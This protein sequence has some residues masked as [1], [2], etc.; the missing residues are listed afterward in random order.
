MKFRV[1]EVAAR[2]G[3]ARVLA[4]GLVEKW[5]SA[6]AALE[7]TAG[8]RKA[9]RRSVAAES[10]REAAEQ[11]IGACVGLG[12]DAV[13]HRVVH[14]GARFEEPTRVTAEVV[15]EIEK[16]SHLAPLHNKLA[17]DGIE[18][19]LKLLPGTPAVAVFDTAFH[20]TIP[21]VAARYA[22]PLEWA[23]NNELRRYGFHGISHKYVT[24]KLLACLRRE[25]KG[26][27]LI[28][29]HLGNGA[30]V[31]AVRD[32]RSV[33]T[34]MGLTPMEGLVMG[35]RSGD[36]DPGLVL[37]LIT[38]LRMSAEQVDELLNRKSG[39][40]GLSGRSGDVRDLEQ[41]AGA[42]DARAEAALESFAYRARKYVGAYAAVL[43][44]VDAIAFT[45][46]IGE[47][48]PGMRAR[49]CRGLEFLGIELDPARDGSP[50]A[51]EA[52]RISR[53]SCAV[54]VWAIPTD[55]ELQIAREV[56]DLLTS[57]DSHE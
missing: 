24:G 9:E 37:H 25:A 17:V 22:L 14:G 55:E 57:R 15:R 16:V 31:C 56:C 21:P 6:E 1:L 5:G 38:S 43:G 27:R 47:H 18:A 30:S 26:T 50:S 36:V 53:E 8:G 7:M 42:G 52:R 23:Q 45:G 4:K 44:G 51:T 34:S 11:A 40:L 19:G 12:I 2:G 46:G 20:R 13:G 35:T 3:E 54:S 49:I 39:L 33:E 41:A 10:S 28:T 48:S 29:C 32:G